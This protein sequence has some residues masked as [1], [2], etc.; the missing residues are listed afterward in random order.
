VTGYTTERLLISDTGMEA[1]QIVE[2]RY[3]NENVAREHVLIDRQKWIY[4]DS[5]DHWVLVSELPSFFYP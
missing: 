3:Y 5:V 4:D 2:I 1:T